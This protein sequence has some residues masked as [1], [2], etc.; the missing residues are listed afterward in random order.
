MISGTFVIS[1]TVFLIV[2]LALFIISGSSTVFGAIATA[3]L[4]T[5]GEV[6][7]ATA[8]T[9]LTIISLI[10]D[11]LSVAPTT[12]LGI[13]VL[14]G[15]II[16]IILIL[17]AIVE[18]LVEF[19]LIIFICILIA[20]MVGLTPLTC[21]L[22]LLCAL[23]VFGILVISFGVYG[24][25]PIVCTILSVTVATLIFTIVGTVNTCFIMFEIIMMA[26]CV[27]M[28]LT[29][30]G[31]AGVAC[32]FSGLTVFVLS[33]F[34]IILYTIFVCCVGIVFPPLWCTIPLA[35]VLFGVCLVFTFTCFPTTTLP[36]LTIACGVSCILAG[37]CLPSLFFG[38]LC[39]AFV[40]IAG[41][42]L[43]IFLCV[44]APV[45]ICMTC[46][47]AIIVICV[48]LIVVV[49]GIVV[50]IVWI[51]VGSILGVT[52]I[53][54][55]G[56]L[57]LAAF[58][59]IAVGVGTLI[60][61][62]ILASTLL[63]IP[64]GDIIRPIFSIFSTGCKTIT[65]LTGQVIPCGG[66]APP[67]EE[68]APQPPVQPAQQLPPQPAAILPQLANLTTNQIMAGGIG[69]LALILL[70]AALS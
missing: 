63:G 17:C 33:S 41:I 53:L 30:T 55:G 44:T 45:S 2:G 15:I 25:Y 9:P 60:F 42:F 67:E 68:P 23:V 66:A 18:G 38:S 46:I 26:I 57:L 56:P 12:V 64:L 8:V 62:A 39:V 3:L 22:S 29:C 34:G 31:G 24:L 69:I 48:G 20:V 1:L 49:G 35:W 59:I 13:S 32:A 7:T 4:G 65:D 51:I 6:L 5:A 58:C 50:M 36:F 43:T 47:G 21:G 40:I 19:L 52:V 70:V 27:I 10:A 61:L 11:V 28:T 37:I 54:F 16:Y 14:F